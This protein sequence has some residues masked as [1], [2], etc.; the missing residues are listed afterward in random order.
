[1]T[2]VEPTQLRFDEFYFLTS[3]K[4]MTTVELGVH[5]IPK[6]RHFFDLTGFF[7]WIPR[8]EEMKKKKQEKEKRGER[9]RKEQERGDRYF[10][11]D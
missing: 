7:F 2:A 11:H 3:G 1:M 10:I 8:G 4:Q 5:E 9:K 6:Q